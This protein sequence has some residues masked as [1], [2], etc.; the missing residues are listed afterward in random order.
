ML[1]Y[2]LHRGSEM[3]GAR[4]GR[5]EEEEEVLREGRK[6]SPLVHWLTHSG[7]GG[8]TLSSLP[9]NPARQNSSVTCVMSY[10]WWLCNQLM[11][12][13]QNRH[14]FHALHCADYI[15]LKLNQS[16]ID[17]RWCPWCRNRL[18]RWSITFCFHL[19]KTLW[20]LDD[21]TSGMTINLQL[22]NYNTSG[23]MPASTLYYAELEESLF[24]CILQKVPTCP[25]W[26]HF[27][28]L[29]PVSELSVLKSHQCSSLFSANCPVFT[30]H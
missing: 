28:V 19:I 25:T 6:Q 17:S 7:T 3:G 20:P 27:K 22:R 13:C 14:D 8:I 2:E 23:F 4:G 16:L 5:D 18:L 9:C 29:C 24:P 26:H 30:A 21:T 12:P 1:I 15:W 11:Q 10:L